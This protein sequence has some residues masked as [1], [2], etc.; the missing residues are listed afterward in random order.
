M[1]TAL[2]HPGLQPRHQFAS[3]LFY[4]VLYRCILEARRAAWLWAGC[5]CVFYLSMSPCL[6]LCLCRQAELALL[7]SLPCFIAAWMLG[8]SYAA[9]V[10]ACVFL[11]RAQQRELG[12]RFCL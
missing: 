1:I 7:Q 6:S 10:S 4:T 3:S 11:C 9:A 12:L 8:S 5:A 2:L